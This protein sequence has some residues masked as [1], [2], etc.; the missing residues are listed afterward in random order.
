M[1]DKD[2]FFQCATVEEL[3][4]ELEE[5]ESWPTELYY[6]YR[7]G[8]MILRT[9]LRRFR[10]FFRNAIRYREFL[11]QDEDWD[12]GFTYTFLLQKLTNMENVFPHNAHIANADKVAK[13]IKIAKALVR[14][15]EED[16]YWEEANQDWK[17]AGYS[18]SN[19]RKYLYDLLLRK[20]DLWW[21]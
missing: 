17:K 8:R 7:R 4:E 2:G 6:K 14:R 21:D 5:K 10:N 9:T 12:Y 18:Y 19:D 15:I 16:N 11:K 1:K 13:D 3:I 20:S